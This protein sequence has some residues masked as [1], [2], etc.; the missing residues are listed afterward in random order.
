MKESHWWRKNTYHAFFRAHVARLHK[1]QHCAPKVASRMFTA[2]FAIAGTAHLGGLWANPQ[3]F[4][5][6]ILW[7]QQIEQLFKTT[8]HYSTLQYHRRENT[9]AHTR[10]TL[11]FLLSFGNILLSLVWW[12]ILYESFG[13][14]KLFSFTTPARCCKKS[15]QY[16]FLAHT[17]CQSPKTGSSWKWLMATWAALYC[18]LLS[19]RPMLVSHS[20]I[21]D[22][23]LFH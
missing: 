16:L 2:S 15:L 18:F 14:P 19:S 12:A 23:C 10:R 21:L 11:T 13:L 6:G 8:F 20:Q 22:I 1:F 7:S 9:V 4:D 3:P 5:F 17:L